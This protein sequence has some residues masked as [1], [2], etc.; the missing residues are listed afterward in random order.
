MPHTALALLITAAALHAG[1]N[2]LVK[3]AAEKQVFTWLALAVGSACFAPFILAGSS[4]PTQVWPYVNANALM[5]LVY[6]LALTY[7]YGKSVFSLV[8]QLARGAAPALLAVWAVL[9]L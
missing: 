6:F 9:F 4:F 8:Y 7:A 3:R 5:E 1:W 2:L